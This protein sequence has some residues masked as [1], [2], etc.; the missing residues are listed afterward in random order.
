VKAKT[1]VPGNFHYIFSS[2]AL[3]LN[4]AR[5]PCVLSMLQK[6]AAA[7]SLPLSVYFTQQVIRRALDSINNDATIPAIVPS[8]AWLFIVILFQESGSCLDSIIN[9]MLKRDMDNR[10]TALIAEKYRTIDYR[11]FEDPAA[12]DAMSRVGQE[13]QYKI[14]EIYR[15]GL[16]SLSMLVSIIGTSLVIARVSPFFSLLFFVAVAFQILFSSKAIK[17]MNTMFSNQSPRERE[18][19]YLSGL[20]EQKDPVFELKLFGSVKYILDKW[21]R[22]NRQVLDERLAT[23]IRAERYGAVSFLLTI[24]WTVFVFI[25]LLDS[26]ATG[27]IAI[28][29]FIAVI[30]SLNAI[31]A[32]SDSLSWTFSEVMRKC[33]FIKYYD[34]F[35]NF[36]DEEETASGGAASL[37]ENTDIEFK[38]V[39]FTYP[40][41]EKEILRDVSF[42]IRQGRRAALAG[43][44][45]AGKSTIIKLLLRLYKP[46]RGEI[47][48][49]GVNLNDIPREGIRKLFS[50]VFQDYAFYSLSLRENTAFGN[51]A[52]L[53]DDGA[54]YGALAM[55]MA[56]DLVSLSAKGLDTGLGKIEE[57]GV[58][59]SGGQKQRLAI[60]RACAGEGEFIILDEPT[61]AMDPAAESKLY[62]T[63]S[64]I[65]KGR[66]CVMVS[67]RMASAR[68]A[69]LILLI[70]RGQV[71]ESGTHGELMERNGLYAKMY[72]NQAEWYEEGR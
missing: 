15:R 19:D 40:G 34:Q 32:L 24:A 17:D 22:I 60:S 23:T 43:E 26:L 69:D 12:A 18:L 29:V 68:L 46:D 33:L 36:P 71:R 16:E 55:G 13:P 63:F 30:V 21:K 61:A 44:N 52:K 28:D 53:N 10:F 9:I 56:D 3:V 14:L 72:Q 58:D 64:A 20:L 27:R 51:I 54:L 50:A 7:L 62:E 41:T 42:T 11:Y 1:G 39:S 66:G 6:A 47:T 48:I 45:G 57:D 5:V 4:Y 8:L 35:M 70:D 59:L 65:L 37:P 67:H 38:N 49:G 31:L 2:I 25:Y